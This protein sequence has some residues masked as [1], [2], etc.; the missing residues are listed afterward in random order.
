MSSA[1]YKKLA[2]MGGAYGN[3]PA[4]Q[5][6]VGDARAHDC[7]G[8]FF[9]GDAIGFAGH[10]DEV[11]A[12]IFAQFDIFL[13][14]NL[15][16]QA[17]GGST[18]CACGYGAE[19]DEI[20]GCRSFEWSLRS[21]GDRNRGKLGQ[22]SEKALVPT[23]AGRVLLC[24]GSPEVQNEFLYASTT[25]DSRLIDWLDRYDVQG[26]ACTHTG[27]PWY[28]P[29][30]GGRFFVNCGVTGK[31]DHDG[32]AAVHYAIVTTDGGFGVTIRRI[33][34]AHTSFASQLEKEGVED[35]FVSPLR[36]G[37]WT[38]GVKS[39]PLVEQDPGRPGAGES[40]AFYKP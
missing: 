17:A 4:L 37:V 13:A 25:P 38:C 8:L 5:A 9:L 34:Y 23:L 32:D 16:S 22:L 36:T 29:L 1:P 31:P 27:I 6:C 7:D 40:S 11:V 18:S 26:I 33:S 21:L 19:E 2:L 35:I 28:R 12:Y 30:P 10:S 14:G 3:L 24:H 20:T 15:E 39:L